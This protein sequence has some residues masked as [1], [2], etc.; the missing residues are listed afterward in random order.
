MTTHQA[1]IIGDNICT[2][3][4]HPPDYFSLD[5]NRRQRGFLR[6]VSA[7][8]ADTIQPGAIIIGG[9]NFGCGSSREV[10]AQVFHDRG[11][12]IV[13]ARSF[14]RIFYR[15]MVNLGI[16]VCRFQGA[17]PWQHGT[18]ITVQYDAE[19]CQIKTNQASLTYEPPSSFVKHLVACGGLLP[20]IDILFSHAV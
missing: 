12:K 2:D 14:A 3:L 10:T 18:E 6:G 1:Y 15:N 11:V 19:A 7:K 13:L 17:H 4:I 9:E 5:K 16:P 20:A 8:W